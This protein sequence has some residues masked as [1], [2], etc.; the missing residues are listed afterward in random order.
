M[1]S[2]TDDVRPPASRRPV[3][4]LAAILIATAGA[5]FAVLRTGTFRT[6]AF[7]TATA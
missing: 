7:A 1:S 5:C 2:K 4:W 6:P 3:A